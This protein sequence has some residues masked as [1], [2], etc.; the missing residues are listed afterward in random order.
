MS[1]FIR[2]LDSFKIIFIIIQ[3]CHA[4]IVS[5]YCCTQSLFSFESIVSSLE[6][7]ARI[8]TVA[9]DKNKL[10]RPITTDSLLQYSFR[11]RSMF[12]HECRDKNIYCCMQK[13]ARNSVKQNFKQ[14]CH[15]LFFWIVSFSR[16]WH[17]CCI[18]VSFIPNLVI[19]VTAA[20]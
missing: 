19:I 8:Q 16:F 12:S 9:V 1:V 2:F 4:M 13:W 3:Q 15:R 18:I 7:T 6:H 5:T 20:M 10:T 14:H 11:S 17:C